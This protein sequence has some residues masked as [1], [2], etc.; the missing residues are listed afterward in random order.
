MEKKQIWDRLRD[1]GV[2]TQP[3][4]LG[5]GAARDPGCPFPDKI[6]DFIHFNFKFICFKEHTFSKP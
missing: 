4:G 1:T 5:R 6:F 2:K 3:Q